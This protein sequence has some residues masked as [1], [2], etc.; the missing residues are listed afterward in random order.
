[1]I[2]QYASCR[3]LN[4]ERVVYVSDTLKSYNRH[5]ENSGVYLTAIYCTL[6]TVVSVASAVVADNLSMDE[7]YAFP[8][9]IAIGGMGLGVW[10]ATKAEKVKRQVKYRISQLEREIQ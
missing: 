4:L 2:P 5:L 7:D 6:G 10:I 3:N 1:M 9:L 8:L